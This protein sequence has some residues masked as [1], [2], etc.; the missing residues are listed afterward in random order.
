MN[1]TPRHIDYA[2][3]YD[4]ACDFTSRYNLSEQAHHDLVTAMQVVARN[5]LSAAEAKLAENALLNAAAKVAK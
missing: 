5:E 3:I 4:C 1:D 2:F